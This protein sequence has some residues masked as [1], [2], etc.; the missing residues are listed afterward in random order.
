MI[1]KKTMH[2]V[3]KLLLS[4]M[5]AMSVFKNATGGFKE[6]RICKIKFHHFCLH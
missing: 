3:G 1:S 2:Y 5:F 6:C 4:A